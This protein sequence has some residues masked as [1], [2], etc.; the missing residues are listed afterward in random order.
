[1]SFAVPQFKITKIKN[2]NGHIISML[3]WTACG[4]YFVIVV[5]GIKTNVFLFMIRTIVEKFTVSRFSITPTNNFFAYK[6]CFVLGRR[7]CTIG[8]NAR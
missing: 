8:N 4:I 3:V 1:M 7:Y 5:V 2:Q 6:R